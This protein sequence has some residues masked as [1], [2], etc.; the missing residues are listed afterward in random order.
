M[1]SFEETEALLERYPN[2]ANRGWHFITDEEYLRYRFS[3]KNINY[4]VHVGRL[5]SGVRPLN[6]NLVYDIVRNKDMFD[7]MLYDFES[8]KE[9]SVLVCPRNGDTLSIGVNRVELLRSIEQMVDDGDIKLYNEDREYI[10]RLRDAC[11]FRNMDKEYE[12]YVQNF[13]FGTEL[14][15]LKY[16][17]IAEAF[18]LD[19]QAFEDFLENF[20]EQKYGVKKE[21]FLA[22][23][24]GF[25]TSQ[26]IFAKY[27]FPQTQLVRA[28]KLNDYAYIDYEAEHDFVAK[29]E[30]AVHDAKLNP[31]LHNYIYK[32]M[33]SSYSKLEKASYIYSKLCKT[34]SYDTAFFAV[35]QDD[36]H[37]VPFHR[38]LEHISEITPSNNQVVCYEFNLIF[39][40]FLEELD[41]PYRMEHQWA[42]DFQ[43][44][45]HSSLKFCV[46]KSIVNADST[47]SIFSGDLSLNKFGT[48]IEGLY[49]TNKNSNTAMRC[50]RII[51]SVDRVVGEQ[52]KTQKRIYPMPLTQVRQINYE[53]AVSIYQGLVR[54][55]SQ[56]QCDISQKVLMVLQGLESVKLF[57]FDA[58]AYSQ[59]LQRAIL[60]KDEVDNNMRIAFV[61]N[62]GDNNQFK[63]SAV[64]SIGTDLAKLG[65]AEQY[66]TYEGGDTLREITLEGLRDEFESGKLERIPTSTPP[67]PGLDKVEV[68]TDADAFTVTK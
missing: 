8:G 26:N 18:M 6:E 10:T 44:G 29:P 1:L 2:W 68:S 64:I 58:I 49:S 17:D 5:G 36:V 53:S 30:K 24:E 52:L 51:E 11:S 21:V 33:P 31:V 23:M 37:K 25:I 50:N 38:D 22:G 13:Y 20:D 27:D 63:T 47:V 61:K 9:A 57:D 42:D 43:L 66:Y 41:I 16:Q 67:I 19:E 7:E 15:Q 3:G 55:K 59:R 4:S 32:D 65:E 45:G 40:K 56:N 54:Q 48:H 39:A 12:D 46:G 28:I 62:N 34:L 35:N 60:T 14:Y